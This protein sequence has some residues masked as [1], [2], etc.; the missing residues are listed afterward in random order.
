MLIETG[1]FMCRG[2]LKLASAGMTLERRL[3]ALTANSEKL[4]S[5][6]S[7]GCLGHRTQSGRTTRRVLVHMWPILIDVTSSSD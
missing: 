7:I 4:E 5:H 2:A 6:L 1:E 3:Q